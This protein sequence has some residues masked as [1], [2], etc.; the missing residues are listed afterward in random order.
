M[1]VLDEFFLRLPD[2]ASIFNRFEDIDKAMLIF[3][4]TAASKEFLI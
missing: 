1:S 2:M 4:T 3:T